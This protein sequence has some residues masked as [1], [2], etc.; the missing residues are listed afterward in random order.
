MRTG[1]GSHRMYVILIRSTGKIVTYKTVHLK[2]HPF[3]FKNLKF[4]TTV[5]TM[6][7]LLPLCLRIRIAIPSLLVIFLIFLPIA[8]C[9]SNEVIFTELCDG[10]C[11]GD[12][13]H[14][15]TPV[16]ACYNGQALFPDDPSWGDSDVH[17]EIIVD[18]SLLIRVFYQ[19]Q[20]GSCQEPTD[21]YS[22][23]LD[24]C[25]GPFGKPRPWGKFTLASNHETA[26][27]RV[28]LLR[29]TEV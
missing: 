7:L 2:I 21:E 28:D 3:D 22:L 9:A 4:M 20:D 27:T 8:R 14:Y 1:T 12:C 18:E 5:N 13:V 6:K 25:L 11:E 29:L 16:G 17:D 26:V 23:P 19:S 24:A 10:F 15:E